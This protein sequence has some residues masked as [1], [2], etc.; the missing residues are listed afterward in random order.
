MLFNQDF[1]EERGSSISWAIRKYAPRSQIT[2]P[3]PHNS[4]FFTGRMPFLSPNQQRQSTDGKQQ[5]Q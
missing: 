1:S 2:M 3:A 4:D 5:Q